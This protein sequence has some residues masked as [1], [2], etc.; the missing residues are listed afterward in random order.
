MGLS[1]HILLGIT[2]VF[3]GPQVIGIPLNM[4]MVIGG[5]FFGIFIGATP[6]LAGPMAMAIA[7]PILISYLIEFET[8]E[9]NVKLLHSFEW[10]K[11][12]KINEKSKRF[13]S[14]RINFI[15]QRFIGPVIQVVSW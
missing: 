7:L 5:L 11:G 10:N 3:T 4:M 13:H 15:S 14:P 1:D 9:L 6:G 8:S 12:R 2:A